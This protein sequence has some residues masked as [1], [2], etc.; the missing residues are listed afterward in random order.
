M[1]RGLVPA[2]E[3]GNNICKVLVSFRVRNSLI[4]DMVKF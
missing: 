4:S 2:M 1:I 3:E